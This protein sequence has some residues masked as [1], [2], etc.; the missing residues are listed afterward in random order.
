MDG[1]PIKFRVQRLG[2]CVVADTLSELREVTGGD[3][4]G[5]QVMAD[6]QWVAVADI[7]ERGGCWKPKKCFHYCFHVGLLGYNTA[8]PHQLTSPHLTRLL[9][10]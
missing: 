4:R 8:R 6:S 10:A 1:K 7:C 2:V 5:L 3:M 9:C